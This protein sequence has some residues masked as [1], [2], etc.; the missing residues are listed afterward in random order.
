MFKLSVLYWNV[1]GINKS[2]TYTS[3]NE[4][5]DR[6]GID[7]ALI[8]ETHIMA[9]DIG[10]LDNSKYDVVSSSHSISRK[11]GV[12]ILMRNTFNSNI[13]E[14]GNY[15]AG[16]ISYIKGTLADKKM[17]FISAYAPNILDPSFYAQL[18]KK[19]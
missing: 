3:C 11:N 12:M 10:K 5:L 19:L 4:F 1:Q 18:T 6:K 13:A 2:T 9:S 16:R 7:I 8:Q 15:S 14:Q 17:A